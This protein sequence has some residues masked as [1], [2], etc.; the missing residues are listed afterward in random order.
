MH[1]NTMNREEK[2]K[3]KS[4]GVYGTLVHV[5]IFM[6]ATTHTHQLEFGKSA[7]PSCTTGLSMEWHEWRYN[8]CVMG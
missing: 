4:D 3:K 2:E 5:T 1:D 7:I 8:V 6:Y